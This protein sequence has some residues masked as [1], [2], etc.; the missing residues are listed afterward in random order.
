MYIERLLD[1]IFM[2][3][4]ISVGGWCI[5]SLMPLHFLFGVYPMHVARIFDTTRKIRNSKL[6]NFENSELHISHYQLFHKFAKISH[7]LMK[8]TIAFEQCQI[9]GTPVLNWWYRI[10]G[11]TIGN[12]VSLS[13]IELRDFDLISMSKACQSVMQ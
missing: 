6:R 1:M 4:I 5:A 9:S 11:A 13:S 3:F 10:L 2:E 7:S 12:N 8:L